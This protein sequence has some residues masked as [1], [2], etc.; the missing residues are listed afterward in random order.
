[1][2][3]EMQLRVLSGLNR[4]PEMFKTTPVYL[5]GDEPWFTV[6]KALEAYHDG[7]TDMLGLL[8]G[9][10]SKYGPEHFDALLSVL[11]NSMAVPG[12]RWVATQVR[13]LKAVAKMMH[14]RREEQ[15]A[16]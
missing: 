10:D 8:R 5:C 14:G 12:K 3:N 15:H 6:R 7:K 2:R 13:Q 16:A 9:M 4:Y 1:M 11:E